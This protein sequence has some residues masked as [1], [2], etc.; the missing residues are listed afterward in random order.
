MRFLAGRRTQVAKGAVCK[1]AMQRFEP[2]RRLQTELAR[3]GGFAVVVGDGQKIL[4][5]LSTQEM[6]WVKLTARRGEC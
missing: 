5:L 4:H 3:P 1:T 6:E 2:A